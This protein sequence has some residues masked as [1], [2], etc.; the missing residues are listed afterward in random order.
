[1]TSSRFVS[2]YNR[3]FEG[4]RHN[5]YVHP[6]LEKLKEFLVDH[7]RRNAAAQHDTRVIVFAQYRSSV[8]EILNYLRGTDL[9]RPTAFVGQQKKNSEVVKMPEEGHE[10]DG[11]QLYDG[12]P[13]K[14]SRS[15]ASFFGKE[16]VSVASSVAPMSNM[17][18]TASGQTQKQQQSVLR[19]FKS[20]KFNILVA[21]CI[22][23]EG[24]DIGEVDLLV[25]YE[26]VSSPTR[27]LQRK[28]RTGRKR[29]GRVVVLLTEGSEYQKHKRSIQ[30]Y[31]QVTTLLKNKANS[32]QLCPVTD[33][34][35]D[36]HFHPR[37]VQES[38]VI[39]DYHYS[40]IGGHTPKK[41]NR[42][43]AIQEFRDTAERRAR[44][45]RFFASEKGR[46]LLQELER[47]PVDSELD[48]CPTMDSLN[49]RMELGEVY[50][51]S[52]SDRNRILQK[53]GEWITQKRWCEE[54]SSELVNEWIKL[55]QAHRGSVGKECTF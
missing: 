27:L 49:G 55:E 21:T 15:I 26:G 48:T 43:S 45:E 33:T 46:W 8:Q 39:S 12:P 9:L 5:E 37:L 17:S 31:N 7:F 19:D 35:F 54:Y 24:L 44:Q 29:A 10:V 53:M 18:T 41:R 50:Q 23:E 3:V 13:P 25:C 40:Q 20:G 32:L 38:L 51:C 47:D 1:M 52:H 22:A 6:K 11:E 42:N 30:K 4:V 28:G 2:Y 14:Q 16:D 34:L 36:T